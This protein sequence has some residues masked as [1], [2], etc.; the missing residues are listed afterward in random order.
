[1]PTEKLD[2]EVAAEQL[3]TARDRKAN[4]DETFAI[5]ERLVAQARVQLRLSGQR[6]PMGGTP[7]AQ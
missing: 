7:Q 4:S 6:K 3:R 2:P 5:R 1:V